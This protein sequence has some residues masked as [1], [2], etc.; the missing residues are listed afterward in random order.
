VVT[1]NGL[2][3]SASKCWANAERSRLEARLATDATPEGLSQ[4][5]NDRNE[6]GFSFLIRWYW[7]CLFQDV[8]VVAREASSE[9]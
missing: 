1:L 3:T 8:A 7:P 2:P 5:R 6:N 9:E 4:R